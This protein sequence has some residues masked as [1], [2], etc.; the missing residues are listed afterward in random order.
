MKICHNENCKSGQDSGSVG[1]PEAFEAAAPDKATC[2]YRPSG[3]ANNNKKQ[4]V[5]KTCMI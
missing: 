1:L 4:E 2:W 5:E 3:T